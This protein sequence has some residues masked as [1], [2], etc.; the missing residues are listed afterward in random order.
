[1]EIHARSTVDTPREEPARNRRAELQAWYLGGLQPKLIRAAETG[2][3][4]PGA[5]D[6][7]DAQVRELLALP[8][9]RAEQAA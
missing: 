8:R 4:A 6:A 5:V 1:M 9:V 7:L 3:A 2:T